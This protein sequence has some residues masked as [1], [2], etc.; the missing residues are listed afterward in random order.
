MRAVSFEMPEVLPRS[1]GSGSSLQESAHSSKL[2]ITSGAS[3]TTSLTASQKDVF[4]MEEKIRWP[5]TERQ[6]LDERYL[7]AKSK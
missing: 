7:K 1:E 6:E 3:S 5:L 4:G 2:S